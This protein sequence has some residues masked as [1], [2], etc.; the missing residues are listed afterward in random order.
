MMRQHGPETAQR[1]GRNARSQQWDIAFKVGAD[2]ILP[3]TLTGT[4][5]GC[6]KAVRKGERAAWLEHAC[7]AISAGAW[8]AFKSY[9]V[10]EPLRPSI[11]AS[12]P[13]GD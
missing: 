2:K 11:G 1:L 3:P 12:P 8:A 10:H 9:G 6:Q 13:V 7:S 4:I 5:T